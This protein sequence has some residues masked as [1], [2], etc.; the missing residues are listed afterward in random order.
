MANGFDTTEESYVGDDP[1]GIGYDEA[2]TSVA[3]GVG[4]GSQNI[5]TGGNETTGEVLSQAG[6]NQARGITATNP[7]PDSFFSRIFGPENVNY[8]A[9]GIDTQGIANLAYDRYL[10]PFG[11]I[12]RGTKF[13][14]LKLREGMSE[15][16]KTRYGEVISVDRPQGIGET[17]ARTAF[18]LGTP[19]GPLASLIGTDQ[20]AL[21]PDDKTGFR[22]SP[23]YDPKLDPNSP[24]YQGPQSMLGGIGRF[25]EQIT[26]GGARP[27]TKT[28][29]G[30]LDLMQGQEAEKEMKDSV[31]QTGSNVKL[32]PESFLKNESIRDPMYFDPSPG[33]MRAVFGEGVASLLGGLTPAEAMRYANITKPSETG[34]VPPYSDPLL[35]RDQQ[36]AKDVS[37]ILAYRNYIKGT[38]RIPENMAFADLYDK[39]TP[40]TTDYMESLGFTRPF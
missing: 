31:D 38:D 4:Y 5:D 2:G 27:V 37:N 33:R 20:L 11:N 35:S 18:G 9:L 14:D 34:T 13:E 40:G 23:N 19:L 26:F 1:T 25:A 8:A 6:F 21:A 32:G 17:I 3:S 24:E 10:N 7:F 16:E 30:I 36:I 28:G 12:T 22:G 39:T 15:G 29:K